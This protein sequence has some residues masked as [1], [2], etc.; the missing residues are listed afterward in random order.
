MAQCF[1]SQISTLIDSWR[2]HV[3]LE[4]NHSL[5]ATT[6]SA[7]SNSRKKS[8]TAFHNKTAGSIPSLQRA[9]IS[10]LRR[11]SGNAAHWSMSVT[12]SSFWWIWLRTQINISIHSTKNSLGDISELLL[13]STMK[14]RRIWERWWPKPKHRMQLWN[15]VES[16][17]RWLAIWKTLLLLQRTW[18]AQ[19]W[20]RKWW[21][22]NKN[23]RMKNV[24]FVNFK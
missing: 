16:Q 11:T 3:G 15:L 12:E 22:Q 5:L 14:S 13:K 1:Q 24:T 21:K 20:L 17:K 9:A 6:L 23:W 19:I 2:K 10:N 7:D 4:L 18:E 8:A